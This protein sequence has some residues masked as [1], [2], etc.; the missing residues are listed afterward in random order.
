M[1]P[2]HNNYYCAFCGKLSSTSDNFY[3]SEIVDYPL[4]ICKTCLSRG[5]KSIVSHDHKKR[6]NKMKSL[7]SG[8][9]LPTPK[10]IKSYLDQYVISQEQAKKNLSVAV[11]NHYRKVF[12]N[13]VD[14]GKDSGDK[15]ELEKSNILM[16]GPT[17]TGKTLLA[18]TLAR[19]LNIPFALA[20]ATT[21]TE[22][23]YVGED[24]ENILLTLIQNAQ[25]DIEKAEA[26]IVYIDEIDK[27]RRTSGNVSITR[28]VGGEG[29]Q[30]SLLKIIEGTIASV[31]QKRGRKHPQ[32]DTIKLDTTNI[33]FICGGAFVDLIEII[34]N[35]LSKSQIGFQAK[36]ISPTQAYNQLISQVQYEDLVQF[37]L[38]PEFI[39]R[40]PVIVT[41]NE[42]SQ[43]DLVRILL[44]PKN[45]LIKQYQR[46]FELE[47][48]RL[49]VTPEAVNALARLAMER[50][51]GAR[52][53]RTIVESIM[54]N[55]MFELPSLKNVQECIVHEGVILEDEDPEYV[56]KSA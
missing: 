33:L 19:F 18:R 5:Y 21:V 51:T 44:E 41:L 42:L 34:R 20:D 27:I 36:N 56:K 43:P 2:T 13:L 54:L 25:Y 46:F 3:S 52:G 39:G 17:G 15:V 53:L 22:A 29:V 10:Q 16:I 35:R 11:Y 48:T 49:V 37:G 32:Q 7:L 9:S 45:S 24:V 47:D 1:V 55:I 14:R 6:A 8:E 23:G 26:G 50:K 4:L 30:Q 12:A 38:I 40:V 28:D 31:P